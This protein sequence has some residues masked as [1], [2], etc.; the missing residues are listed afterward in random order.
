MFNGSSVSS[1]QSIVSEFFSRNYPNGQR[2]VGGTTDSRSGVGVGRK[3]LTSQSLESTV[4]LNNLFRD[5]RF[6]LTQKPK[7]LQSS[8]RNVITSGLETVYS[9]GASI[10]VKDP[11]DPEGARV[12]TGSA[13]ANYILLNSTITTNASADFIGTDAA[14]LNQLANAS[15]DVATAGYTFGPNGEHYPHGNHTSVPNAGQVSGGSRMVL[16]ESTFGPGEKEWYLDR[17]RMLQGMSNADGIP[18]FGSPSALVDGFDFDIENGRQNITVHGTYVPGFSSASVAISDEIINASM[19]KAYIAPIIIEFMIYMNSNNTDIFFTGSP[20]LSRAGD[21][22]IQGNNFTPLE[23]GDTVS[24]HVMGRALDLGGATNR[25]GTRGKLN[26]AQSGEPVE[27][28]REALEILLDELNTLGASRPD[29]IPDLIMI[30]DDLAS[31]YGLN[32]GGLEDAATYVKQQYPNLLYVNFGTDGNHN[33]HIHISFA[34]QRSGV[35][36][37]PGGALGGTPSANAAYDGLIEGDAA[38]YADTIVAPSSTVLEVYG[39]PVYTKNY[40]TTPSDTMTK[41][42]IAML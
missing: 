34:P 31:V 24:A 32:S 36:I 11:S 16:L 41:E 19:Q 20:G 22:N 4:S 9:Q 1:S 42:Q 14:F 33:N 6:V 5:P 7:L 13:A 23:D 38:Y 21:P 37:G 30:H 8:L 35:Y 26:F 10:S 28:Y 18:S 12:L 2:I 39:D 27:V 15:S 29:L 3:T 17:A 25:D 40:A